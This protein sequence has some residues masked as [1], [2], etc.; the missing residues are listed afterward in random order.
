MNQGPH[1]PA[2]AQQMALPLFTPTVIERRGDEYVVKPGK[3]VAWL[4]VA[5]FGRAVG[6]RPKSVYAHLGT[7]ALPEELIEYSGPRTI[8]IKA[9]AL[10][11]CRDYWLQRRGLA[12]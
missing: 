6:L 1:S 10:Q 4:S 3:P 8:R 11:F 7:E 9:E 12:G 2:T 5:E